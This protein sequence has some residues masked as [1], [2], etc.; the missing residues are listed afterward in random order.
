[1]INDPKYKEMTTGKK[2]MKVIIVKD[3]LV[4]I[5]VK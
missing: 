2:V 3:K 5:V 1:M 4:N